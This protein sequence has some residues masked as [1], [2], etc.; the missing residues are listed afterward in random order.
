MSDPSEKTKGARV[1]PERRQVQRRT[2]KR[3]G[4]RAADRIVALKKPDPW[5]RAK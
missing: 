3:G 5:G 4:R 1:G 2:A